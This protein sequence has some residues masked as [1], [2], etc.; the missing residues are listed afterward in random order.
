MFG[1]YKRCARED[2]S[3]LACQVISLVYAVKESREII[4][5]FPSSQMTTLQSLVIIS[6]VEEEMLS[7]QFATYMKENKYTINKN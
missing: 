6:F 7:F 5:E 2:I 1:G 3:F 4:G